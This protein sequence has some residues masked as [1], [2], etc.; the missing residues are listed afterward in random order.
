MHDFNW[1]KSWFVAW[2]ET[3]AAL[4]SV[5]RKEQLSLRVPSFRMVSANPFIGGGAGETWF[6]VAGFY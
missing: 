1:A 3:A 2:K 5:Y 4:S 6:L